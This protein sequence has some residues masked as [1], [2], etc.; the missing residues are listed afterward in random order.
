[1][2]GTTE[3]EKKSTPIWIEKFIFPVLVGVVLAL[4]G[5]FIASFDAFKPLEVTIENKLAL[6]IVVQ[7]NNKPEY[8]AV[9]NPG[10]SATIPLLSAT[11]FPAHIFWRVQRNKNN[12][13]E[14]IGEDLKNFGNADEADVAVTL[15]RG[16]KYVVDNMIGISTYFYP[17]IENSTDMRCT[18]IVND[19]LTIQYVIGQSSPQ[20]T[21]NQTG[22]YKYASNSNVTLECLNTIYY[23]G[24]R[25]GT[26]GPALIMEGQSGIV[27]IP[28]P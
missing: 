15:D 16:G 12:L 8:S 21:A 17:V 13:G 27:K 1:M 24:K 3:P 7:V 26:P 14:P 2:A 9:I 28:I 6:A 5:A 11:E 18:I 19:G 4:F 22:Y 25:N 23:R 10:A 20:T